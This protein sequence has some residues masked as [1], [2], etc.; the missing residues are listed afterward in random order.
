MMPDVCSHCG[1]TEDNRSKWGC[2]ACKLGPSG[3]KDGPAWRCQLLT[4]RHCT[5]LECRPPTHL[6]DFATVSAKEDA[7]IKAA[8]LAAREGGDPSIIR[9]P[10]CNHALNYAIDRDVIR[11][12]V[13]DFELPGEALHA[14]GFVRKSAPSPYDLARQALADKC[15]ALTEENKT[16]ALRIVRLERGK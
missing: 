2:A 9:L 4:D 14:L 16:L 13:C 5:H 10:P 8:E 3:V 6:E 11:C 15:Q 1:A 7:I 12:D